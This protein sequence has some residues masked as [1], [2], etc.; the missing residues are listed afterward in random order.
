MGKQIESYEDFEQDW[1]KRHKASLPKKRKVSSFST[2][3]WVLFWILVAAGAAVFSGAHTIP[4]AELTILK[5]LANRTALASTAFV[6]VE[7]VLFGSAAKR[8]EIAWLKWL[9][10]CS[11]LVALIGNTS[12]SILAVT[13]NGGNAFNQLA[14]V[15]LSFIAPVTAL[16]AGEVLHIQLAALN[17]KQNE[18]NEEYLGKWK[19]VEA[20]INAAYTKFDRERNQSEAV[21]LVNFTEFTGFTKRN[22]ISPKMEIAIAWLKEHPEHLETESRELANLIGVSHTLANGA[23]KVVLASQN[24]HSEDSQEQS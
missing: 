11:L 22:R 19:D 9:M 16:A 18:A 23:R 10:Y 5:K 8:H 12:S 1:K 14:G 13:E 24:G 3:F 7:L 2:V 15:L 17:L 21:K 6:I 4:S 20:K